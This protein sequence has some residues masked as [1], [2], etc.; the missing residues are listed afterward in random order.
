MIVYKYCIFIHTL[1]K[2][3]NRTDLRPSQSDKVPGKRAEKSAVVIAPDESE[4]FLLNIT[5]AAPISLWR[6][7]EK[8]NITY[9]NKT[10]NEWTGMTPDETLGKGWLNAVIFDDRQRAADKFISDLEKRHYYEVN[11]RI[12]NKDGDVRWC[13]ATGN[14]QY[15]ADG[16]FAGY[17]GA[18]TDVSEKKLAEIQLHLKNE[19]LNDQIKQ[20]EFVTGFMPVQLWT[21][22]VDGELDYVNQ[23]GLDFFGGQLEDIIG[24][25][26]ILKVHPEDRDGCIY[27]WTHALQTGEVYQCEF[28]LLNAAG[29]YK[30]HLAR[31]LP[32]V[33]DGKIVKWF[34]TNTDIDGQK[35]LQRQKD[36]FLGIASHELKTPVTSIKAYAQVLGAMLTKEGELKKA[37][38]VQR[39]DAQVNRLTNLIGDLLDVTKINAGKLQFNR[40]WFDFNRVISETVE[41]LQHTTQRHK[42]IMEFTETGRVYADRDRVSQVIINLITNAIKYSPYSDTIII[43]TMITDGQAILSVKDFGLGIP[44]DKI[45]MVFEQFYRVSGNKQNTFPGLGLGLYISSEIVKREGGTIW[46]N[47]TEGKG[48]DFCFSLPLFNHHKDNS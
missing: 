45:D 28:R 11:F 36:D 31:A 5:D 19:E 13:V 44:A 27:A 25:K 43:K 48:S 15:R 39:M 9:T 2:M 3:T 4:H 41:D 32:F 20:F 26:W 23:R 34:G 24:P 46:V 35:I 22:T 33:S 37:D 8:G 16:S 47:S 12:L 7:D 6:S 42:L 29:E 21:A 18:C 38:M 14:P 17:I 1:P 30:W 40:N 10:W